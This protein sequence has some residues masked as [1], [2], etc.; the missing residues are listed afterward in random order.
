MRLVDPLIAELEQEAESTRRVLE[1]VPESELGWR[2][3]EKSMSLGQ[4]AL[5]IATTPGGVAQIAEL[6]SMERPNFNDRP[7]AKSRREVLEALQ[8]SVATAREFLRGLD[9]ARATETWSMT[10]AGKPIFS[11]PRIGL[12]RTIMLNHWYHHRGEMQV[13]LRLLGVPVPSVYGPTADED[14]FVASRAGELQTT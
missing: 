10:W 14:P 2:P 11:L 1:R 9:D 12:V 6:D 4:L 13:Y 7:E 8:Q 3:H 5:H